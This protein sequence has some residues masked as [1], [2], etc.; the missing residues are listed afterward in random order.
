MMLPEQAAGKKFFL[1]WDVPKPARRLLSF[2]RAAVSVPAAR[3]GGDTVKMM[4]EEIRQRVSVR[5]WLERSGVP[6]DR[7]G[8]ALCPFHG[9]HDKSLK[10]YDDPAR[11]W[12]CFGCGRGG[13]VIDL[14][15]LWHGIS[16]RQAVVRLNDE[17]R[18]GLPLTG[19]EGL[20]RRRQ[21]MEAEQLQKAQEDARKQAQEAAQAAYWDAMGKYLA[22]VRLCDKYRPVRPEEDFSPI[23]AAALRDLP[24]LREEWLAAWDGW[25]AA[26]GGR[27]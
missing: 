7:K 24:R 20:A 1:G 2:L 17:Y 19:R 9:D 15:M 10:C 5:S 23:Y 3:K 27:W 8:F 13:S 21:R 11:G 12:H 4:A 6:V 26:G 14:C 16:F 25:M 18:L 22:C